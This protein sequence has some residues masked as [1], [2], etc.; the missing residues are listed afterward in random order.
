MLSLIAAARDIHMEN[1]RSLNQK[2]DSL[3]VILK[4]YVTWQWRLPPPHILF[5]YQ[6]PHLTVISYINS[7]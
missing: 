5:N 7:H 2:L 6:L 1:L 4:F 3:Y